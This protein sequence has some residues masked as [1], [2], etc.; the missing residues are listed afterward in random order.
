[1]IAG[2]FWTD[3]TTAASTGVKVTH[4][5]GVDIAARDGCRFVQSKGLK[6]VRYVAGELGISDGSGLGWT[7]PELYILY[8]NGATG[9]SH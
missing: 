1:M 9:G 3:L 2:R 6:P 4:A 7:A 5:V 8:L